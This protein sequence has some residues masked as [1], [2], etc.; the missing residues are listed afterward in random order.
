MQRFVFVSVGSAV[1]DNV[2]NIAL[3]GYFEGKA[4]AEAAIM[5]SVSVKKGI[6]KREG[7][8]NSGGK[9]YQICS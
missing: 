6:V 9:L 2:G 1:R 4:Q 7:K 5:V 8:A 3:K